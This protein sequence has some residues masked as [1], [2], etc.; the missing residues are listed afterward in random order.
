M[1]GLVG[2]TH[3]DETAEIAHKTLQSMSGLMRHHETLVQDPL[4]TD[5]CMGGTRVHAGIIQ[6]DSQPLEDQGVYVWLDGDFRNRD[7]L[8]FGDHLSDPAIL[9][10]LYQEAQDFSFLRLLNGEFAAV[11]YD[12]HQRKIHLITD[13]F[14][15]KHLYWTIH[16]NNL[17]WAAEYKA[18][19]A[20]P[21]FQ[22]Q[23]NRQALDHFHD[24]GHFAGD[25]TWFEG[26]ELMSWAQV[27]TWDV[28][29]RTLH[30][31]TYWTWDEIPAFPNG[32]TETD[33]MQEIGRRFTT[34]IERRCQP[35]LRVGT[36]LSGGLD[37]RAILAV[38]DTCADHLTAIT[39]GQESCDDV[40]IARRVT[41]Q[42]PEKINHC[43]YE[44]T[45]ENWLLSRIKPI[46]A[47]DGEV[48][49][50]HLH[51]GPA[52]ARY[53]SQV[54]TLM[55][56][57]LGGAFIGGVYRSAYKGKHVQKMNDRGRRL[58][59]SYRKINEV[60]VVIREPFYDNDLLDFVMA[61]PPHLYQQKYIYRKL[62]V[63]MFPKYFQS[64]PYGNTGLPISWPWF[65]N[66]VAYRAN[67]TRKR[68]VGK[69]EQRQGKRCDDS[70]AILNEDTWFRAEPARTFI[71]NLLRDSDAVYPDYV[72][73]DKVIAAWEAQL[74][75]VNNR[76]LLRKFVTMEIWLRMAFDVD[77]RQRWLAEDYTGFV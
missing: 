58:V 54:E 72:P 55:D 75:G 16:N 65:L 63:A 59:N 50:E 49:L 18:F 22:P 25:Q 60:F 62:L 36:W 14:G 46:W 12:T 7:A 57:M 10:K 13:R 33:V 43:V 5:P 37:S 30:K 2:F 69:W 41:A 40:R 51:Q 20:L 61:L 42:N 19:L 6:N 73:R 67:K 45:A 9:A 1:P 24:H 29:A 56:G 35:D 53:S 15:L 52:L 11:I 48:T 74:R 44:I 4:F 8:G 27:L 66:R 47:L 21:G 64:I 71:D 23:I 76:R 28:A 38:L 70:T 34:A 39:Y 3:T 77:L 68:L 31:E 32:M 17:V 26:V